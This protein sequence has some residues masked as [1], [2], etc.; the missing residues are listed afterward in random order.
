MSFL[1]KLLITL[2]VLFLAIYFYFKYKFTYWES[3]GVPFI[4]PRFPYGNV[5]GRKRKYHSSQVFQRFYNEL[6]HQGIFGGV[7]FFTRPA[8]LITDLNFLKKIMIK[9][10]AYFHD[11]GAYSNVK[12]DPLSGHL[13]NLEGDR[14]KKL[15]EKL[16]PTFTSG[17]MRYMLPTIVSV[18]D[19]LENYLDTTIS[20]DAEPEIKNV[21]ARFTTDIIGKT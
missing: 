10:F 7:Y 6:K 8:C 11:R 13:L 5:Q 4:K 9:D 21:L 3:I 16:S 2:C 18:A 17:K 14:W 1:L 12:D 15:R 20:Q 19:R